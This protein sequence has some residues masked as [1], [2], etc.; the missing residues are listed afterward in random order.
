MSNEAAELVLAC[1][2]LPKP[3][4]TSAQYRTWFSIW[5]VYGS[6]YLC[7]VNIGPVRK[8]IQGELLITPLEMGFV[9]GALKIGY[10]LGQL[11]NGQIVERFGAKRVL[12]A[13]IF[14]SVASSLFF[15]LIPD[16]HLFRI[17]SLG[18]L[19]SQLMIFWFIN[20]YFQA[21][22]WPA[23][24][25]IVS[26]WF[27]TVQRGRVMGVV[28]TSYQIGSAVT[29]LGSGW[30]L[31]YVGNWRASF[32]VPSILF[33]L[34]GLFALWSIRSAPVDGDVREGRLT[35][36]PP[37]LPWADT[38][39]TTLTNPAVWLL[40][41]G[42]F[43]LAIVRYGFYD[44]VPGQLQ[45]LQGT[46]PALSALKVAVFPLSGAFGSLASNWVS[47]RYFGGRRAPAIALFI[48]FVAIFSF[49]Y[50]YVL[51]FGTVAT[52]IC[53]AGVGFFVNGAQILLAGT[54]AQDL[55]RKETAAAAAGFIDFFGYL[56]AFF[57]D[58]VTGWILTKGSYGTAT[59]FWAGAATI[60]A[61]C[62]LPLWRARAN[63]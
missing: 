40:A 16:A 19:P 35:I 17:G 25:K 61:L 10:A 8:A 48:G 28:G 21:G 52:V 15:S 11:I 13:A 14:G 30:L 1:E 43:G 34:V 46:S 37:K 31:S 32:W 62:V 7:R 44:W 18:T 9:L 5:V 51:P 54:A 4:L 42:L 38:L 22:G 58:V 39:T 23:C 36:P 6:F 41:L 56:G 49:V 12:I 2:L 63:S 57:G 53:L 3:S 47:D 50:G 20:G 24:V 45:E 29:L 27:T 60:A 33:G 26:R 55:A 59:L